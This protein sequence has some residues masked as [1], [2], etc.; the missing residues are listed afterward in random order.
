MCSAY[1]TRLVKN[2]MHVLSHVRS[3]YN[4]SLAALANFTHTVHTIH[5]H[6]VIK[7]KEK[8]RPLLD[9]KK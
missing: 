3:K 7:R 1:L 2:L 8:K 4:T 6:S 9:N 5:N